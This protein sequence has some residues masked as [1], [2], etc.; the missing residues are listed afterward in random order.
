MM[1]V[2]HRPRAPLK[3]S[4]EQNQSIGRCSTQSSHHCVVI[5]LLMGLQSLTVAAA[6]MVDRN[7]INTLIRFYN[8]S[9]LKQHLK[10]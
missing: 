10:T 6:V 7:I 4:I 5:D 2:D 8:I 3:T 1:T 9:L